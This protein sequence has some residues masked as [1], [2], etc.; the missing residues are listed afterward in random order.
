MRPSA[1]TLRTR[2][3]LLLAA[4]LLIACAGVGGASTVALRS[5]L[6]HR[7]DQQL[8]A[9]GNRYAIALEH[10]DQGADNAETSTIG[11]S[12]GTLGA[13]V[14]AGTVTAAGVVPDA[15]ANINPN[16]NAT[17]NPNA[18][19]NINPNAN[20]SVNATV[21]AADR[22]R[23]LTVAA[24]TGRRSVAFPDLGHYRVLVLNGRDGDVLITGLP[25]TGVHQTVAH[26]LLVETAVFAVV[27]VLVAGLGSLAVGS[28]LR[29]LRRMTATAGRIATL[30]LAGDP[31]LP[32]RVEAPD[33]RTEIGTLALAVNHM[34][35]HVEQS[36]NERHR[37]EERL[38]QFVADA[39]HE[40]RTPVAV[41]H[42]HSELIAQQSGP[43]P[44]QVSASL[45]RI[46]A[47][48][49]RMAR[50]VDELLLLAR[51][52]AGQ[53]LAQVDVDVSRLVLETVEDA[54]LTDPTHRFDLSLPP[55]P[56]S[57]TGDPD[58]LRQVLVNLVGNARHHTPAGT[59]VTV[60]GRAD[61]DGVLLEVH[62]DGPGIP[63]HL[64]PTVTQRFVRADKGRSRARGVPVADGASSGLGLAIVSGVVSAHRGRLS[65]DSRADG[66]TVRVW[67]P[68]PANP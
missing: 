22:A 33:D 49:T 46:A 16:A 24:T 59:R 53:P 57:V 39:S 60:S 48:S 68:G 5:F 51:L 29:P 43:L 1:W 12:A 55:E 9:A 15:N 66:T 13:R 8:D 25:E 45:E 23:L 7:L 63:Q 11:Q 28:T 2:L 30:P 42:S 21:S 50:L 14:S 3:S 40:L 34:L 26:V 64:L 20:P 31:Q 27:V 54:R 67:L 58:R 6:L 37:S 10:S 18:N 19:P 61:S 62:D 35:D 65:L 44:G 36:L 47:E 4:L 17:I 38:R 41:I 56:L 52:D 32:E